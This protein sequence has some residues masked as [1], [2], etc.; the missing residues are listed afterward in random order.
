VKESNVVSHYLADNLLALRKQRGMSQ[1]SLSDL[2]AIPRSTITHIESGQGNPS[3]SNLCKLATA[4]NVSIEELLSRPRSECTL[5]P[6]SEVPVQARSGGKAKLFKL[7]PDRVRGI[8]IDRIEI[9]AHAS[10]GGKPHVQGSKEYL[11]TLDGEVTVSVAGEEYRVTPGDVLAFP[12]DQRHA[13]RNHGTEPVVAVSVV[14]PMP[15]LLE[16]QP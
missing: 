7:M 4:L 16:R 10:M 15:Y 6:A 14:L 3:L 13:Y 11:M 1:N 9:E 12:G 2:A 8:E 5:L